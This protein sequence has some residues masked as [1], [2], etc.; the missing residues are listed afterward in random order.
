MSPSP[1]TAD[2]ETTGLGTSVATELPRVAG[3]RGVHVRC[4]SSR[5]HPVHAHWRFDDAHVLCP[6]PPI[7][8]PSSSNVVSSHPWTCNC[9]HPSCYMSYL[10]KSASRTFRSARQ[11]TTFSCVVCMPFTPSVLCPISVPPRCCESSSPR[12]KRLSGSLS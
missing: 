4:S 3:S 6:L 11:R 2:E 12:N 7:V 5:S 9:S 8:S 10:P 1:A